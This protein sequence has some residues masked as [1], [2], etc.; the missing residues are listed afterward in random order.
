MD[1][2]A[3]REGARGREREVGKPR[4]KNAG[5]ENYSFFKRVGRKHG[6]KGGAPR[7]LVGCRAGVFE[8][9]VQL[10]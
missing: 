1:K 3:V 6:H 8:S 4:S 9:T 5:H 7:Q 2:R 10:D